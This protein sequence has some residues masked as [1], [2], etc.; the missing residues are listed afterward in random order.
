MNCSMLEIGPNINY[1]LLTLT[2]LT[3]EEGVLISSCY[4]LELCNGKD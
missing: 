3:A 4:S 2:A 1:V